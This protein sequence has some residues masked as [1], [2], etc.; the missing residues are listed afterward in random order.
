MRAAPDDDFFCDEER[1]LAENLTANS[2]DDLINAIMERTAWHQATGEWCMAVEF[3]RHHTIDLCGP[4]SYRAP[5]ITAHESE[6]ADAI[7]DDAETAAAEDTTAPLAQQAAALGEAPHQLDTETLAD[8]ETTLGDEDDS[9]DEQI[10]D[11]F[12]ATGTGDGF[13][14]DDPEAPD[15]DEDA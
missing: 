5:D 14:L 7:A 4:T 11:G 6:V 8:V 15:E 12:T 3:Q 1:R 9:D 2:P 10:G 13:Q